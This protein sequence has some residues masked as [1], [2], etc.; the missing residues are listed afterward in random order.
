M[1]LAFTSDQEELRESV[2]AVLTKECPPSVIRE[3]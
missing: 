1:Q 2:R 3:R